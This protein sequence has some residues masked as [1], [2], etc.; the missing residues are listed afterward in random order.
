MLVMLH[1]IHYTPFTAV[2]K[3]RKRKVFATSIYF[4]RIIPEFVLLAGTFLAERGHNG[5]VHLV[6]VPQ[7]IVF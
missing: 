2:T 7:K 3:D 6:T 4:L 1:K 5:Y